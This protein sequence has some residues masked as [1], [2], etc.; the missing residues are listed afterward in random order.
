M[1]AT[2][3]WRWRRQR[4]DGDGGGGGSADGVGVGGGAVKRY[5]VRML[6]GVELMY[7]CLASIV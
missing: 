4:N 2:R 5:G 6:Y 3:R 1:E 7:L